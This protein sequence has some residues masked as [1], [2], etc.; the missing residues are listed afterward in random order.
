MKPLIVI[1]STLIGIILLLVVA[2]LIFINQPRFG[3]SAEGTRANKI[4][5][6]PHFQKDHFENTVP[7]TT[8]S[9]D[10]DNKLTAI[11]NFIFGKRDTNL[12]PKNGLPSVKKDLKNIPR[13]QD[14]FVWLGHSSF[15]MQLN[16]VRIL[17]DPVLSDYGS[18]VSFINK[19]FPNTPKYTADDFPN[20]DVLI[21]S[22]DHWDHLDYDTIRDLEPKVK[23]VIVPLG[24]G[25]D[26]AKWGYDES[27]IFDGDWNDSVEIYTDNKNGTN[28][29]QIEPTMKIYLTE[30]Q[31]FSGRFLKQNPTLWSGFAFITPNKRVFYSGD[32]GYGKHF[33][34]IGEKYGPFDL[35][36]MED[37]QYN[38][39]WAKIHM[40]PEESVQ[41]ALD[42]DAKVAIPIHNSK[43]ALAFHP[44]FEPLERFAKAA[45]EER[46]TIATPIMGDIY[47]IDNNE[48]HNNL[49][50]ESTTNESNKENKTTYWWQNVPKNE[51]L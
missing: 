12:V 13:T 47:Y 46:L 30:S 14:V 10:D 43:F 35:A 1:I 44:W 22:H 9:N 29:A 26:F 42:V 37:V 45:E 28:D 31:H 48:D 51:D 4:Q 3:Y 41:A 33:K 50:N 40:T 18:P 15:F 27:K 34:E 36:I 16:G 19:A 21:I 11:W 20:I 49:D 2:G 24:I 25:A 8:M 7:V 6:S 23:Q 32:G 17:A 5:S 39:K 38:E